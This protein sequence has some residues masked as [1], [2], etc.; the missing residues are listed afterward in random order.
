MSTIE[1][2]NFQSRVNT[3]IKDNVKFIAEDQGL[4]PE[5]CLSHWDANGAEGVG[6]ALTDHQRQV[7]LNFAPVVI[8]EVQ[9]GDYLN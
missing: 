6:E 4:T 1:I 5:G 3:Y 8:A 2:T 7:F 9:D